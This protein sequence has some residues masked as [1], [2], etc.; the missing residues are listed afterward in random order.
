VITIGI[1]AQPPRR[2][3]EQ[4]NAMTAIM[5]SGPAK[6]RSIASLSAASATP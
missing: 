4:A 6:P 1:P 2:I 5:P 3:F